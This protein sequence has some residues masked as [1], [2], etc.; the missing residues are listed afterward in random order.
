MLAVGEKVA[1]LLALC[2]KEAARDEEVLADADPLEVAEAVKDA[3]AA[4]LALS[5]GD[6]ARD[7][8]APGLPLKDGVAA[9]D[10]EMLTLE[11]ND[12]TTAADAV[13]LVD[14]DA[15]VLPL[16]N[17][18]AVADGDIVEDAVHDVLVKRVAKHATKSMKA[19]T[20]NRKRERGAI[21]CFVTFNVQLPL[22]KNRHSPIIPQTWEENEV[23]SAAVSFSCRFI[24]GV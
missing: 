14:G 11:E 8:D 1:S 5:E 17:D 21:V 22:L 19:W 13:Q 16:L 20:R 12:A 3:D 10:Q 24:A 7:S 18:D 15:L 23:P 2:D 4:L 6:A 9:E